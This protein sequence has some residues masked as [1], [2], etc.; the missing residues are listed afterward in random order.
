MKRNRLSVLLVALVAFA[1]GM[2]VMAV[3]CPYGVYL[4]G[5]LTLYCDEQ[6][7]KRTGVTYPIDYL[8]ITPGW[9]GIKESITTV[10]FDG[11]QYTAITDVSNA[12]ESANGDAGTIYDLNGRRVSSQSLTKGIYIKDGKK[13]VVK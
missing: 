11:S 10:R 4:P 8:T 1:S 13:I 9:L 2:K 12:A 3:T 6:M 7:N 5:T